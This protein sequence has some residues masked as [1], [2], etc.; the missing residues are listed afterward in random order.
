MYTTNLIKVLQDKVNSVTNSADVHYL[1]EAIRRLNIGTVKTVSSY[2]EMLSLF[3][4]HG[5]V[6]FVESEGILYFSVRGLG[7]T[8][9]IE[10]ANVFAL[11][12]GAGAAG[13]LGDNTT[14]GRSSPVSVV[15]GFT[16][17][18]QVS[19]SYNHNL[20][21]RSNG[22]AW[23]WGNN[24][25]GRLGDGTTGNRSSPASVIGGFT[26]WV[27]LSAG[28][29][30]SLGLLD[31]GTAW[32]WGQNTNGRLGDNSNA[33]RSSPVSVVGGFTDWTQL[34]AM[35]HSLG[36]RANGTAWAWGLNNFG[37]LGDNTTVDKSSPVSV[38]G[39]VIWSQLTTGET[40][41]LGI[42]SDGTAWAW[43]R[44]NSGQLG[45]GSTV[46]RSSPVSI[47]GGF[48]DWTH[49]SAGRL[50]SL[51]IR[52]NG[53]AWS[54]GYNLVGQLGD[55]SSSFFGR[56]SP[57]SV[58]G[59]FTDWVKVYSGLNHSIGLRSNGSAW[60]WGAN[61]SGQLGDNST[62]SR[63]SPVSVVGGITWIQINAGRYHNAGLR[64]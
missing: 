28:I 55:G 59:G 21:L 36:L 22:T 47:V 38:V 29:S 41:S 19:T 61:N 32:A 4:R 31:S 63:L 35:G 56:S 2:S 46:S 33:Y 26:N 24:T 60:A 6:V 16:D 50:H 30:H 20:G 7:W 37:Q 9:I 34:S 13:A 8:K 17:W 53:T 12:W 3:A 27:Q 10:T 40:H 15:G 57:G 58:V 42:R 54:W 52:A 39:G 25:N 43:G 48:T 5:D 44:N 45:D 14:V 51:G 23:A 49:L 64:I 18:T 62:T 11:A 1:S